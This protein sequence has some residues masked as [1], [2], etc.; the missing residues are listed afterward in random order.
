MTFPTLVGN[1]HWVFDSV[2]GKR[3]YGFSAKSANHIRLFNRI[4]EY[5]SI[6]KS[7]PGGNML[8]AEKTSVQLKRAPIA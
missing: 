5:K 6:V 3:P 1:I 4:L 7:V 2:S 8:W